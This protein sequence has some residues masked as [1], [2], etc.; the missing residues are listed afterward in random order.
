MDMNM[1]AIQTEIS[2]QAIVSKIKFDPIQ[3]ALRSMTE[4]KTYY[5]GDFYIYDSSALELALDFSATSSPQIDSLNANMMA[6]KYETAI[7]KHRKV[8]SSIPTIRDYFELDAINNVED[9]EKSFYKASEK[10]GW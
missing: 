2:P 7:T 10:F 5:R 9:V 8:W 1:Q 3:N 6:S 4:G